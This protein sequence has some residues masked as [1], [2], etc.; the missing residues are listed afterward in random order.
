MSKCKAGA[1][2]QFPYLDLL[3][4]PFLY[5]HITMNPDRLSE[6][7][8]QPFPNCGTQ[9][10]HHVVNIPREKSRPT[11][12]YTSIHPTSFLGSIICT[13]IFNSRA[14]RRLRSHRALLMPSP[15]IALRATRRANCGS[16]ACATT[17]HL[18]LA[19]VRGNKNVREL[20]IA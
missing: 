3:Y 13:S 2:V 17:M 15:T 20:V 14:Q 4:F 8:N 12:T 9:Y 18:Q 11:Y 6:H 7:D 10:A 19:T 1:R 5:Y 16:G